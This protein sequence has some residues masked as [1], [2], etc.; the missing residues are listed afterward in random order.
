MC[1]RMTRR[2][3]VPQKA[4]RPSAMV[5]SDILPRGEA[6]ERHFLIPLCLVSGQVYRCTTTNSQTTSYNMFL[7]IMGVV[8]LSI[9]TREPRGSHRPVLALLRGRLGCRYPHRARLS[10]AICAYALR[11]VRAVAALAPKVATYHAGLP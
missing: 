8:E 7:I 3:Q 2:F 4:K 10:P 5:V 9:K 11:L 1:L 6:R